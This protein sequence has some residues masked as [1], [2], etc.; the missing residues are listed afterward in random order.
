MKR[1]L[2]ELKLELIPLYIVGFGL[3][4]LFVNYMKWNNQQKMLYYIILGLCT[5]GVIYYTRCKTPAL[6]RASRWIKKRRNP[7]I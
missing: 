2:Q 6:T 3:S 4:E 7:G 1:I 5:F